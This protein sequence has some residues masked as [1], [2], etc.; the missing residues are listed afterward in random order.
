MRWT[1]LSVTDDPGS[2]VWAQGIDEEARKD[3]AELRKKEEKRQEK[4]DKK[5]AHAEDDDIK[6][7]IDEYELQT[8]MVNYEEK[9][10]FD[11]FN[12]VRG[13]PASQTRPCKAFGY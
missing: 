11:D 2:C 8:Q 10:T 1:V 9:G 3:R 13:H 5:S 12:E 4:L 7:K 6:D